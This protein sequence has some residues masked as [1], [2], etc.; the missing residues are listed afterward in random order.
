MIGGKMKTISDEEYELFQ[1]LKTIVL[2]SEPERSGVYFI[3]GEGGERDSM[4]LPEKINVCPAY[5]LDGMAQYTKTKDYSAP[6]W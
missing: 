1:K 6:E 5:G 3:C 2:H 4:G